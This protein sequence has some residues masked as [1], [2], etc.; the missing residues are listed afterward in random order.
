MADAAQH[1]A[2]GLQ[3]DIAG[4]P[5]EVLAEGIIGGEEE[6]GVEAA[7]DRGKPGHVGLRIGVEHIMHAGGRAGFVG[8]TDRTG[9]IETTILLRAFVTSSPASAVADAATS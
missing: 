6:P 9:T 7:F 5:F 2:A 1:L 4:V 3:H 8:E